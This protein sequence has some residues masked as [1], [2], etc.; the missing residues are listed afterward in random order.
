MAVLLIGGLIAAPIA[1]W[2]V[3]R[4]TTYRRPGGRTSFY[5][6]E[7]VLGIVGITGEAVVAVRI[8]IVVSTVLIVL[9]ARRNN[10]GEAGTSRQAQPRKPATLDVAAG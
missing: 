5:N 4:L 3:S 2:L 1:A 6:A 10:L 9:Y 8:L 7:K